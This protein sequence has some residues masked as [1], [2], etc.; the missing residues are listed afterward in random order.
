MGTGQGKR[1]PRNH[2]MEENVEHTGLWENV[3]VQGETPTI[4]TQDNET[5]GNK[6]EI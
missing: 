2:M 3:S 6:W 1:N 4:Y 5:K